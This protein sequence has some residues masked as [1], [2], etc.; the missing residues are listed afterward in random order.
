MK[1]SGDNSII[2]INDEQAKA[3]QEALKA[4]QG[5]GVF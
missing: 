5:L 4:L 3:I 1:M 2:P